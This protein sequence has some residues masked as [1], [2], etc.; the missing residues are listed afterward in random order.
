LA[1]LHFEVLKHRAYSPDLVPSDYHLFPNLEK[2]HLKRKKR[3]TALR[4]PA[5]S[6]ADYCFAAHP[7]AFYLDGLKKLE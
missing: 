3:S 2:S 1:D 6:T 7:S 4:M 5:M